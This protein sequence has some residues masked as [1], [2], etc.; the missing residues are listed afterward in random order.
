M[1]SPCLITEELLNVFI[2][3]KWRNT[4]FHVYRRNV[5]RVSFTQQNLPNDYCY[6][7]NE[8]M[9]LVPDENV[10]KNSKKPG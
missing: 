4:G 1:A 8:S 10:Y 2:F 9:D 5:N 6:L 3:S 7:E